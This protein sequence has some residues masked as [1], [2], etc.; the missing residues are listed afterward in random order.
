[1]SRD[2]DLLDLMIFEDE[3]ASAFRARYPELT[4]IDPARFLALVNE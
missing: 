3:E 2:K 1:M 4:I